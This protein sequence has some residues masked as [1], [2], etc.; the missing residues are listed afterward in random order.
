MFPEDLLENLT[1]E[2][3][4]DIAGG[5]L[6]FSKVHFGHGCQTPHDE[7]VWLV[8]TVSNLMDHEYQ[9]VMGKKLLKQHVNAVNRVIIERITTQKPMAYLLNQA[10]FAGRLF[11]IDERAI[12][13]RSHIGDI[14]Q[15]GLEPFLANDGKVNKI[16]DLCTGSGCIAVTLAHLYPSATIEAT[17][18]DKSALLVADINIFNYEVDDR[19][20]T[21]CSDL[22]TE[23]HGEQYD[24]IFCNPPYVDDELLDELPKEYSY[25][26]RL[27]LA[28]G[29][30]GTK[31][32]QQVLLEAADYLS[33]HGYLILEAG[34]AVAALEARF[35]KVPFFWL[36]SRSGESVVMLI[37]RSDLLKYREH[38]EKPESLD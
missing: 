1:V 31:I 38:F 9:D 25:E 27:A 8:L 5:L 2:D 13:P 26:P 17:D 18:I 10:W 33:N 24:L 14:L 28:A 15:D 35:P 37:S 3:I 12:I 29:D 23:I 30:N 16:L 11:Y 4:V 22:F 6:S 19:V 32:I 36:T 34:D 7:A 21:I 20:R